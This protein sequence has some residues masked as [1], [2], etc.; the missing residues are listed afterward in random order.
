MKYLALLALFVPGTAVAET[1]VAARTIPPQT[2]LTFDDLM[3]DQTDTQGGVADPFELVGKESRVALYR[4][5]PIR[6]SDVIQPAIIDR[7]QRI[8]LIYNHGGLSIQTEGRALDR[9]AVGDVIPIMNL[10]SRLTVSAEI[11]RDGIA[12][13]GDAP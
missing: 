11:G 4:G 8:S 3:L 7:N 13:V 2:V 6:K 9:A 10:A 12:Y 5:H 1:I